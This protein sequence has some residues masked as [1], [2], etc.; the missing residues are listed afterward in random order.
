MGAVVMGI[1]AVLLAALLVLAVDAAGGWRRVRP[2]TTA[3]EALARPAT[4]AAGLDG[5]I[6]RTRTVAD[7]LQLVLVVALGFTPLGARFVH[8]VAPKADTWHDAAAWLLILI[9]VGAVARLPV[10]WCRRQMRRTRPELFRPRGEPRQRL[11]R[12]AMVAARA[13]NL[14]LW[15]F[16]L[17]LDIRGEAGSYLGLS[18]AFAVTTWLLVL[19]RRIRIRQLPPSDRLSDLVSSL[20]GG[21]RIPV[22]SGWWGAVANVM[23]VGYRRPVI[24]AAP[25]IAAALTD[26]ELRPVLAHEVAHARHGD[27]RRRL[28]RRLLI[29]L[30]ILATMA[31]LY[32]IPALRSQAGLRGRLSAQ[33]GPFLLAVWYLAFRV[34][35]AM[36]LR[37]TRAEE[38][39]ADRD[40][41]SLTGDP[42]ACADGLVRL[43]SLLGVPDAWTLPQRLLFATHPA[44]SERLRS[45]RAPAPVADVQPG[46]GTAGRRAGRWLLVGLLVLGAVV[47]VGA[48]PDHRVIAM[49]A[50]AGKYQV[51]LPRSLD[52]A[53]AEVAST[54]A[55]A[56]LRS[57]VWGSGDLTRFPGAVP[58]TAVY[59][60]DGQPW[61]YVWGAYG[62]LADPAGELSAFWNKFQ[63]LPDAEP[64]GPLG[65]SLQCDDGSLTCAWA[66]DSGIV[67]VSVAGP[68]QLGLAFG[69]IGPEV[70][71]QAL[72]AMTLSLRGTAEVPAPL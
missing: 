61:L 3:D 1:F 2:A 9:A 37:A 15:V 43:S 18:L 7:V 5:N 25:P 39:A 71:E 30:C 50:D 35:Y 56:Q 14:V 68:A 69:Y 26:R 33:A 31:A 29:V 70:T 20:P 34:L 58:V 45:L 47:A 22:V 17:V 54:D 62:K 57:S 52:G 44:T 8:L 4:D 53:T 27:A 36:G 21:P 46:A 28:L 23:V 10:L 49:P 72:A 16:V 24:L 32:G 67:V 51:L 40:M 48:V 12:A 63:S 64:A 60:Q 59:D 66:D 11:A 38:R 42:D 65:G 19:V 6:W 41:V 55:A 13:V